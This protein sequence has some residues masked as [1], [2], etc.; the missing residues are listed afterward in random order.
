MRRV[1]AALMLAPALAFAQAEPAPPGYRPPG[2]RE[3]DP[4]STSTEAPPKWHLSVDPRLAVRFGGGT[5]PRIGYGAG[6]E[7]SRA[8][9][10]VGP[11]RFGVGLA[12]GYHRFAH[13]LPSGESEAV[14]HMTFA[15]RAVLD[16]IFRRLRPYLAAGAGLSVGDYQAS[17][18]AANPMGIADTTVM[19]LVQLALG[20]DVAVYRGIELG[21]HGEVDLTFSSA[22][23]AGMTPYQPGLFALGLDVGFRF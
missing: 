9:V 20:L 10:D 5:L 6:V 16:G 19:A 7:A 23:L 17:P 15:A 2:Q 8:L 12:F 14:S 3:P 1:L 21:L 4:T 18:N 22:S 13:D 11:L